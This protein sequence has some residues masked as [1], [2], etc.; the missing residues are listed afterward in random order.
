MNQKKPAGGGSEKT[1]D[2]KKE[3][4]SKSRESEKAKK[5]LSDRLKER[6]KEI[7]EQDPNIYPLF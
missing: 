4:P 5:P 7:R 3:P 1:D 2:C 6:L